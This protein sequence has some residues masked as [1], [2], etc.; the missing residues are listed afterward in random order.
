MNP[1]HLTLKKTK[2][3]LREFGLNETLRRI[4]KELTRG[5]MPRGDSLDISRVSDRLAIGAAPRSVSAVSDLVDLEF[6]HVIDLRA[7]R[8]ESDL[9]ARGDCLMVSWVPVYDDWHPKPFEFFSTLCTE[10]SHHVESPDGTR[11]FICC[12]AGEHRAPLGG[13]VALVVMGY[14]LDTAGEL[15]LKARPI[16]ELL[17]VYMRSFRAYLK[18]QGNGR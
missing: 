7:E 13:L 1:L 9:L 2:G 3:C 5:L 6:R 17:P 10:I 4:L 11:L 14:P 15:I 16:A 8:K 12:R 18:E